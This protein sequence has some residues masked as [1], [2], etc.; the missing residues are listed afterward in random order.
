MEKKSDI[1]PAS[2]SCISGL[3]KTLL[4]ERTGT[5]KQ[6]SSGR[7]PGTCISGFSVV[8]SS[9]LSSMPLLS[10]RYA[11]VVAWLCWKVQSAE[12]RVIGV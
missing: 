7:R 12:M 3:E 2:S 1:C 6:W 10:L 9:S 5:G 11:I 4:G 8:Q